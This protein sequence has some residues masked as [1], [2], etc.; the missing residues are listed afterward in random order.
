MGG[1][2]HRS[3]RHVR[4]SS[5]PSLDLSQYWLHQHA[6]HQCLSEA[7]SL[8]SLERRVVFARRAPSIGDLIGWKQG[9]VT[10]SLSCAC[11]SSMSWSDWYEMR[12]RHQREELADR[13]IKQ[14]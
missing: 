12:K 2:Y 10:A 13:M 1:F 6:S 7:I 11:E 14:A 9:R 8:V 3:A 4:S 5:K